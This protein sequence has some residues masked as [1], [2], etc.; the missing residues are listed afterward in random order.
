MQTQGRDEEH[1]VPLA[2]ELVNQISVL[3]TVMGCPP[4]MLSCFVY[5]SKLDVW[6][7]NDYMRKLMHPGGCIKV[8][9]HLPEGVQ[10]V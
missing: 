9:S 4:V 3:G 6:K 10:A 7:L 8:Y 2:T 1:W 5:I